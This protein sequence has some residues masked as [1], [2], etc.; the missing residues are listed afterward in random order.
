VT[1]EFPVVHAVTDSAAVVRESFLDRATS[2]MQAL[3]SRGALHL[4][5]SRASGRQF[6]EL[7]SHLAR[8]QESSGCWLIVN[9]RV[10]VAAAVGAR[11]AQLASH[12]LRVAEARLV[13]PAIPLGASIHSVQEA[14]E[15]ER[16]GAAWC[17]AGTVFDTPSHAGRAGARV[18]FIER[19][20]KAVSIPIIAI[21]GVT[22]S[23]VATL[24]R[25]GAY[26]VAT[27][28]GAGWQHGA[29]PSAEEDNLRKT[30]LPLSSDT[31]FVEPVTRYIS[32]YDADSGRGRDD[33]PDG[34]RSNPG[35]GGK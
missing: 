28:R 13:F 4:R 17:V 32:A 18:E 2:I 24:K 9:D 16:E 31:G 1:S 26:G 20:A 27:I 30:R 7:A 8:V 34:E 6:H 33:H 3:G 14:V 10:D 5:S 22:P 12:S 11:G 21:G 35:A 19:V 25:A 15:A 23:D 29:E